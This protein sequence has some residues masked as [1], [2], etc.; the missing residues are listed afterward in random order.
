[1]QGEVADRLAREG[2]FNEI[3]AYVEKFHKEKAVVGIGAH[4]LSTIKG[5]VERGFEPD[6]WMKTIHHDRYWSRM[7]DKGE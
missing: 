7:P 1:M 3:G 4:H 6:F 2:K 5:C